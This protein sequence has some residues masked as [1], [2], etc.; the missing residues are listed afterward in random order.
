MKKILNTY[1]N[2]TS[3]L[4]AIL[5][6]GMALI[7]STLINKGILK[8]Y[9][10][11]S[12]VIFLTIATWYLYKREDV[13]LNKIGLNLN[14]K[15]WLLIPVGILIGGGAFLLAKYLRALY[16]GETINVNTQI[17]TKTILIAFYIILPTVAV[18]EFLFRGYLFKKTTELTS[19]TKAN[20][21]FSLLFMSIHVLDSQ[22]LKN[23]G[24]IVLLVISIPVGHLM[25]A[26]AFLKSK[27]ILLPIGIHLG[28]NWATRHLVS[29]TDNNDSIFY[30]TD[31]VS[32]DTWPSFIAF[33]LLW[34]LLFLLV[35]FVIW[36]FDFTW[37]KNQL[38]Q[39]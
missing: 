27:S 39:E 38:K 4:L 25:Y 13:T 32:F 3:Y 29:T 36:K 6:F 8:S 30:V 7:T 26:T 17:D 15:N 10:P 35:T 18:E 11:F 33:V 24:M 28:N 37:F 31:N 16:L 5:L 21:I 1:P 19:V 2:L 20:I 12:A 14:L 22:V 23:P 34:N 9:F